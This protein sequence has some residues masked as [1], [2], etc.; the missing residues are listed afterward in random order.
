M[1]LFHKVL[2]PAEVPAM[3]SWTCPVEQRLELLKCFSLTGLDNVITPL[4][5]AVQDLFPGLLCE[6]VRWAICGSISKCSLTTD[7]MC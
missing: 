5:A 4:V 1:E 3:E 2:N 7:M 6:V